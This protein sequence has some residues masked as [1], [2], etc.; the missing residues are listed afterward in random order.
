VYQIFPVLNEFL[1]GELQTRQYWELRSVLAVVT[2]CTVLSTVELPVMHLECVRPGEQLPSLREAY[3][4]HV[5]KTIRYTQCNQWSAHPLVRL[6]HITS[7]VQQRL[8]LIWDSSGG[9]NKTAIFWDVG[10]LKPGQT[11]HCGF[12][13]RTNNRCT[14]FAYISLYPLRY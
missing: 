9:E 5:N 2:S 8:K 7:K 12:K 13:V 14:A 6:I 1:D 11:V 10:V 4:R 3:F